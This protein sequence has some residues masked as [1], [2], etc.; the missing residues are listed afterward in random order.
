MVITG[1]HALLYKSDEVRKRGTI[2]HFRR[3]L[4]VLPPR[5]S[6]FLR[7]ASISSTCM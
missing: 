2:G 4:I 3:W 6:I 5:L 1:A 7:A